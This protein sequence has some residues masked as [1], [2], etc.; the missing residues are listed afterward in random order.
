MKTCFNCKFYSKNRGETEGYCSWHNI[1]THMSTTCG[2]QKQPTKNKEE[3]NA[4]HEI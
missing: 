3:N 2:Y 1:Y 4:T